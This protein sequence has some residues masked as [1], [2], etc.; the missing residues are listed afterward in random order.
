MKSPDSASCW[1]RL[2]EQSDDGDK[3]MTS[4]TLRELAREYA[5]GTLDRESYRRDRAA[6]IDAILSG[7]VQVA[8]ID[9]A[10][11]V[12]SKSMLDT[13]HPGKRRKKDAAEAQV[14]ELDFFDIT[15][16]T[17]GASDTTQVVT[18]VPDITPPRPALSPRQADET[19]DSTTQ[20]SGNQLLI[21]AIVVATLLLL[22]I[23]VTLL[24]RP[25]NKPEANTQTSA[26]AETVAPDTAAETQEPL[27]A[28]TPETAAAP[29]NAAAADAIVE[30]LRMKS[31]S[32]ES[33]S[34][35]SR[36]WQSLPQADRDAAAGSG[37]MSQMANAIYR[38][39]LELRALSQVNGD[40]ESASRQ[41][42]LL[43]FARELGINDPRFA[44]TPAAD[45]G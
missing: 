43:Q 39:L 21:L 41:E 2:A 38:K 15:Q 37:E 20:S 11:P 14:D 7:T 45:P 40:A 24:A 16:V 44:W 33:M 42:R 18:P 25:G 23:G 8:P 6:L 9:F 30:F 22:V 31:W 12:A 28:Q 36:S 13:T 32:D 29:V 34:Q 10:A 26:S 1:T 3:S 5:K 19:S 4:Q 35:F 27:T 17:P